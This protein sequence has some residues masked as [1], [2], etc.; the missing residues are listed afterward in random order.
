MITK[1]IDPVVSE[2]LWK[3]LTDG[4]IPSLLEL[5]SPD[6]VWEFDDIEHGISV[7]T[8]VD[9][10]NNYL[11][12]INDS[13]DVKYRGNKYLA[14]NFKFKGPNE[15]G[16]K[17]GNATITISNLGPEVIKVVDAIKSPCDAKVVASFVKKVED[18]HTKVMFRELAHY[19]FSLEVASVTRTSA[20]FTLNPDSI[21]PLNIPR[22]MMDRNQLNSL[23]QQQ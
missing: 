3:D 17:I 5:Y 4:H 1:A 13:N 16:V 7:H 8:G 19:K 10:E 15:D 11:R 12:V 23:V 2:E 6:I 21:Y 22:D 9:Q 20:T 18:G 14:C